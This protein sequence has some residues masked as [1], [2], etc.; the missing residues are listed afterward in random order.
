MGIS[1][2]N[3]LDTVLLYPNIIIAFTRIEKRAVKFEMKIKED[4]IYGKFGYRILKPELGEVFVRVYSV[5]HNIFEIRTFPGKS[6]CFEDYLIFLE[7]LLEP[8]ILGNCKVSRLDVGC[9]LQIDYETVKRGISVRHKRNLTSY[10][11][12]GKYTGGYVGQKDN[13]IRH[14]DKSK[15]QIKRG[16]I[17]KGAVKLSRIESQRKKRFVPVRHVYE[18]G[19]LAARGELDVITSVLAGVEVSKVT[20]TKTPLNNPRKEARREY[21]RG[22]VDA[23]GWCEARK[24]LNVSN[25]FQ[26]TYGSFVEKELLIDVHSITL[27]S[28]EKYFQSFVESKPKVLMPDSLR[29]NVLL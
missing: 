14:Y 7:L 27:K 3:V 8:N 5:S 19:V 10:Q 4:T 16:K 12:S 28:L 9:T 6:R 18:L 23:V 1:Q 24:S 13:C 15:E 11:E 21:L 20:I 29:K 17:P 26:R 22:W 2:A 25:N